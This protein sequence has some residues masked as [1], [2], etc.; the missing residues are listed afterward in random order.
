MFDLFQHAKINCLP[1]DG[2]VWSDLFPLGW[3]KKGL[4]N[5]TLD[6]LY[7]RIHGYCGMW[8]TDNRLKG[9]V[10]IH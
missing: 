10:D 5:L 6:F 1:N 7:C 9:G 2:L 4:V 3:R 8:T